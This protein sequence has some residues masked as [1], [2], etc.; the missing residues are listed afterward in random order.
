M[1]AY[2]IKTQRRNTMLPTIGSPMEYLAAF[3]IIFVFG[4]LVSAC[5]VLAA[6]AMRPCTWPTP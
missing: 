6:R 5:F 1:S 4:I 2:R 3:A